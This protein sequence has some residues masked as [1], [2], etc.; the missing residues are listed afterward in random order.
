M[1]Q[2]IKLQ[3]KVP[4][5]LADRWQLIRDMQQLPSISVSGTCVGHKPLI[6][7]FAAWCVAHANLHTTGLHNNIAPWLVP[8]DFEPASLPGILQAAPL[9]A[10]DFA[11]FR[12]GRAYSIARLLRSR[13]GYVGELRAIGDVMRDQLKHMQRCGFDAFEVREDKDI[14]DALKG[15]QGYTVHYQTSAIESLPLFRRR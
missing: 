13:Y 9:I 4:V 2:I 3:D 11:D 8:A 7:P 10:I 1:K 6:L 15:L 5:L 14:H 12:D